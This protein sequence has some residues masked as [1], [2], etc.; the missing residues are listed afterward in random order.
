MSDLEFSRMICNVLNL[1]KKLS[2]FSKYSPLWRWWA[3]A[4]LAKQPWHENISKRQVRATKVYVRDTGLLHSLLRI[5]SSEVLAGHPKSGA[6]CE[7]YAI[8]G[9]IQYFDWQPENVF[10]SATHSGAEIDLLVFSN[11]KKIGY[12]FKLADN[13]KSTKSIQASIEALK[14]DK[15]IIVIP[16]KKISFELSAKLKVR[17]LDV[18]IPTAYAVK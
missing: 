18:L 15:L 16:G 8:E 9:L 14:L 17:S 12:E 13:P 6:S 1:N 7:G 3:P 10:Y 5:E 4:K 2:R 11:G